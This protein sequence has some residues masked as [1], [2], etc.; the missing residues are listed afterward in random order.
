MNNEKYN[1]RGTAENDDI[2]FQN[3][4]AEEFD[5]I[6]KELYNH[7]Q[8]FDNIKEWL[9]FVE[10]ESLTEKTVNADKH[11][12]GI[13]LMTIHASKGLEFDDCIIIGLQEGV[14]PTKMSNT[15]ELM[16]EER[17]L[18]YVALTR[19]RNNI[20]LIGR[21]KDNYGKRE[22]R[23]ISESGIEVVI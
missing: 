10:K 4:E 12:G 17:R 19:S 13:Q 16:E 11:G 21:R 15:A 7:A 20:W 1:T 18:F 5:D 14:F 22:S 3:A 8:N 6:I 23:F 2:Y 9:E